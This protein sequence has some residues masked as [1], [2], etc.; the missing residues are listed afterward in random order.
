MKAII[1]L[2]S[3]TCK[4]SGTVCISTAFIHFIY[5]NVEKK[6]TPKNQQILKPNKPTQNTSKPKGGEY[7]NSS[8]EQLFV[9]NYQH[10]IKSRQVIHAII[11]SRIKDKI[12]K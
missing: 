5:W 9:N 11:S 8:T 3:K 12:S 6:K 2:Q 7:L 1:V 10:L 4:D